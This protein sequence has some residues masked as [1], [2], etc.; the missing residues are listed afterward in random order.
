MN[1]SANG[2]HDYP[3]V[4]LRWVRQQIRV[5]VTY[6]LTAADPRRGPHLRRLPLTIG[7]DLGDPE[8]FLRQLIARLAGQLA[9]PE[10]DRQTESVAAALLAEPGVQIIEPDLQVMVAWHLAAAHTMSACAGDPDPWTG[11]S[12]ADHECFDPEL[13]AAELVA[14]GLIAPAWQLRKITTLYND[15]T[16]SSGPADAQR[17]RRRAR[18]SVAPTQ[19][20]L[21]FSA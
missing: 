13:L 15:L 14:S 2:D 20:G 18:H 21:P 6:E 16:I 9:E 3:A 4:W 10:T 11:R 8:V 17:P 7:A 5:A 19:L 12:E 1:S